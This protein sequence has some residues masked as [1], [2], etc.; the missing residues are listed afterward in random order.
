MN[1]T[2]CLGNLPSRVAVAEGAVM[3]ENT[4][5]LEGARE[6]KEPRRDIQVKPR[7]ELVGW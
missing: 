2:T 1:R 3:I 5:P 6:E 4:A 7:E